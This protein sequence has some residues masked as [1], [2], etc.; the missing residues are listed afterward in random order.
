MKKSSAIVL[1]AGSLLAGSAFAQNSVT[2]YGIADI[3]V[4]YTN[5]SDAANNNLYQLTDGAV[6]Q[7]RWGI[8]G[9]EALGNNLKAIFQLENGYSL[10]T[11]R[12]N[13]ANT[14]FNRQAYVGLSG[15]FGA[16][17]FG[18]QYTEGFNFFGDYDPLTIGNYTANAWP[19]F[20]TQFR[21]NNVAS[22][23]GKFGGLDVGA[24]YGFG[25]TPGAFTSNQ[26]WGTRAAY[27]YGP[28]GIGGIYQQIRNFAGQK[29]EMWGAAGK[30]KIGPAQ[31]FL[32][33]LGGIDRTGGIDNNFMN[34]SAASQTPLAQAAIVAGSVNNPRKDNLGYIG[35]T[36][37]LTP[38]LAL[39][40]AFYYDYI[41]N[42]NGIAGN[43]GHRYTGVALAEYSLS[44]RTQV[45]GTVDYN[46]LSGGATTELPGANNQ[47]GV[48][49][50]IRHI[51]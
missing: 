9:S 21:N 24:S 37:Q 3:S 48:A 18:R 41:K 15:D 45:Y 40:G 28:F 2:L 38:A 14:L 13:S 34:Q 29:Q 30:Y 19:F 50:G 42:K 10:D 17:K 16:V 26:Y 4:R 43:G 5:H 31:I 35:T 8:K 22:Y 7:S 36:Y 27:T 32:G 20:L 44:K 33:Y 23:G 46:H 25:E 49:A 39:T 1:A 51:F 47:L 11:G 12:L 6:T